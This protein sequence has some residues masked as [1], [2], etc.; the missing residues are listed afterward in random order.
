MRFHCAAAIKK[1]SPKT[2]FANAL[3]GRDEVRTK[4]KRAICK[5][6]T[7]WNKTTI[8]KRYDWLKTVEQLK[9]PEG[10]KWD[11]FKAHCEAISFDGL[12]QEIKDAMWHLRA[13]EF[14]KRMRRCGIGGY[15]TGRE[16]R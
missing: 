1:H 10:V 15:K 12:P 5:F 4:L 9:V 7:E 16:M 2:S 11:Q 8:A 13:K 3:V 6:P 14:I